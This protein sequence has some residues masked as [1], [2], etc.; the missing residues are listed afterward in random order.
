MNRVQS[1]SQWN[2]MS[3]PS[4]AIAQTNSS[5]VG[6]TNSSN[7]LLLMNVPDDREL[8]VPTLFTGDAASSFLALAIMS[9][10]DAFMAALTLSG[11]R[12]TSIGNFDTDLWIEKMSNGGVAP[13]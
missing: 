3:A 2:T 4:S 7:C 1:Q 10:M 5:H 12:L 11:I 6:N 8:A 9:G 13:G